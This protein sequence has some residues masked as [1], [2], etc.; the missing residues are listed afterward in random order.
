MSVLVDA[1]GGLERR[2]Y[3]LAAW[4][5]PPEDAVGYWKA[6]APLPEGPARPKPISPG[7]MLDLFEQLKESDSP[8]ARA[9]RYVLGLLLLRRKVL[10]LHRIESAGGREVLVLGRP[11]SDATLT[12]SDPGLNENDLVELEEKLTAMLASASEAS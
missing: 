9:L 12:V 5:G 10:H 3:S 11:K 1:P 2:D 4:N 6:R 7:A 8:D